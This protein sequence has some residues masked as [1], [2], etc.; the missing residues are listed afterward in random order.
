MKA[1]VKQHV[2]IALLCKHLLLTKMAAGQNEA[3][4]SYDRGRRLCF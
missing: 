3:A 2:L 1:K 4:L